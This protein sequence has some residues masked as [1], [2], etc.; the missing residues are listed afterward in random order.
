MT[1]LDTFCPIL[2]VVGKRKVFL[3][4]KKRSFTH[5]K[6]T[7]ECESCLHQ[8]LTI[9]LMW[10]EWWIF[11]AHI[12]YVRWHKHIACWSL[13]I[14]HWQMWNRDRKKRSFSL[15]LTSMLTKDLHKASSHQ[16]RT[17]FKMLLLVPQLFVFENTQY[18]SYMERKIFS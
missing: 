9:H 14:E 18:T 2:C 6:F 4:R 16:I 5:Q 1:F 3:G 13:H 10:R 11:G 7:I 12:C 15:P 17:F 8:N